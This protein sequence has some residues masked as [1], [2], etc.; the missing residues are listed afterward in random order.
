MV[1]TDE[2]QYKTYILPFISTLRYFSSNACPSSPD[3][4]LQSS[5][6]SASGLFGLTKR[7]AR[8]CMRN[9]RVCAYVSNAN[10][11][12]MKVIGNRWYLGSENG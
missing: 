8:C 7:A 1:T 4:A 9:S 3:A 2:K 5:T 6:F 10:S 11:W 12:W